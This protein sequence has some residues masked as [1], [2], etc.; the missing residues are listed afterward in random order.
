MCEGE[1]GVCVGL[2]CG[3]PEVVPAVSAGADVSCADVV[4]RSGTAATEDGEVARG[5]GVADAAVGCG[6]AAA[7]G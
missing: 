7:N 4:V 1:V 6:E 2:V 3:V 5:C